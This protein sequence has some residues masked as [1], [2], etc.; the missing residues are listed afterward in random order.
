[1]PYYLNQL[2]R[3][4]GAAHFEVPIERGIEL[5]SQMRE[6]LPGYAVP[7]FVHEISG[8]NSKTVIA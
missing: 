8:R 7:R 4:R 6:R 5:I 1:M 2:D 3:V